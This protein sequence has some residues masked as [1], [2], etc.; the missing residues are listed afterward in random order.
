MKI[1]KHVSKSEKTIFDSIIK[2]IIKYE[3]NTV[4]IFVAVPRNY[5]I[6]TDF[7]GESS[8]VNIKN[9]RLLTS[10]NSI[11]QIN[12][13]IKNS[14]LNITNK[15]QKILQK[16]L[17]ITLFVHSSYMSHA[18]SKLPSQNKKILNF[19]KKQFEISCKINAMGL[20]LHLPSTTNFNKY[21]MKPFKWL[22]NMEKQIQIKTKNKKCVLLYE[23]N[24]GLAENVIYNLNPQ[25]LNKFNN[26]VLDTAH[27]WSSGI[28]LAEPSYTKVFLKHLNPKKVKLIHFNDNNHRFE[29]GLDEHNSLFKGKIWKLY[30]VP[31]IDVSKP[32]TKNIMNKLRQTGAYEIVKYAKKN[33]IPIIFE[34][35][36]VYPY[37]FM[38]CQT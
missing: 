15:Q 3:M 5:N 14:N 27:L 2:E 17:P 32:L 38:F 8:S 20:V 19:I 11:S 18:W 37:E 23:T 12:K 13:I 31:N 34:R 21:E 35:H 22:S 7:I 1:G 29:S 33:K 10:T 24:S 6:M 4:Q 9:I 30:E 16:N 36:K 28:D 26:I 25:I